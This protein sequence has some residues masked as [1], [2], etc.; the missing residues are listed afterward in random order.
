MIFAARRK[1]QRWDLEALETATRA[2]LHHAGATLLEQLLTAPVEAAPK[3][4]LTVLGAV[5]IERSYYLCPACHQG[6]LPFDREL[7]VENTHYSPGV[8]RRIAPVGSE[9]SFES[10]RAQLQPLAG[11]DVTAKAVERGAEAIGVDLAAREQQQI[12]RAVQLPLLQG[13]GAD[14]PVLY[15]E[16]DGTGVPMVA[17]KTAGRAGKNDSERARTREVKLG[18][19]F[20]QPECEQDGRPVREEASTSYSGSDRG[21]RA[22]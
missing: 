4:L 13:A 5:E 21:R 11:L 16:M 14:I 18:C 6:Q 15:I 2:A 12:Q 19:M 17:A 9:S 8:R 20:T 7:D 22:V 3:I 1:H 10:R